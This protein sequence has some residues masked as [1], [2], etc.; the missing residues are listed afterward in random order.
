[1]PDY[2]T[3]RPSQTSA[4]PAPRRPPDYAAIEAA[5]LQS[6]RGRAFLAEYARRNRTADTQMLL[7]AITRLE[8]AILRPHHQREANNVLT[9][10]VEMSEAIARTRREI[11]A[12]KPPGSITAATEEL[13]SVVNATEKATSDI[14][15]AAE[16]VQEVAWILREQGI[17]VGSCET[18]DRGHYRTANGEGGEGAAL[19]RAADQRHDRDLGPR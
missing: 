12:I 8:L 7:E 14:L 13:E 9:D 5:L 18:L 6:P 11:A 1:M 3:D 10:L 2:A 19:R 17:E 15:Q 16:E 4:P